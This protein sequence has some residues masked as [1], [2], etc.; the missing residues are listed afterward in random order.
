[1]VSPNNKQ[2]HED[3]LQYSLTL[4]STNISATNKW[5]GTTD[6]QAINQTIYDFKND[7]N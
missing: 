6:T 4:R 1:M 7:F 2:Q 3:H 5:C